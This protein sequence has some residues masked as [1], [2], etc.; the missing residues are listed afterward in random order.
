MKK[1]RCPFGE[2][3]LSYKQ[4]WWACFCSILCESMLSFLSSSVSY[5]SLYRC[6]MLI[7]VIITPLPHLHS[8][9][10][11]RKHSFQGVLLAGRKIWAHHELLEPSCKVKKTFLEK[12]WSCNW[13]LMNKP[14][15]NEHVNGRIKLFLHFSLTSLVLIDLIVWKVKL[16]SCV[17]VDL[18]LHVCDLPLL[19]VCKPVKHRISPRHGVREKNEKQ[20]LGPR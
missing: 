15:S 6:V 19:V 9:T 11:W 13:V 16:C 12:L 18:R 20:T 7:T 1:P 3:T 5:V 17:C 4:L 14:R 8:L 10:H 2:V